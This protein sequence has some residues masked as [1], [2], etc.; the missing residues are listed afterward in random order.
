[1][2]WVVQEGQTVYDLAIQLYG[3]IDSLAKIIAITGGLGDPKA[4]TEIEYSPEDSIVTTFFATKN[5]GTSLPK[6]R[7]FDLQ[8]DLSFN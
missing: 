5:I 7:V 8:F 6:E 3:S 2:T 1:M 4:G